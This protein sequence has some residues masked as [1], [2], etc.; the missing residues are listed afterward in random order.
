MKKKVSETSI[1]GDKITQEQDDMSK[2]EKVGSI[3]EGTKNLSVITAPPYK[4]K[5]EYK[6]GTNDKKRDFR[7]RESSVSRSNDDVL[8]RNLNAE[9]KKRI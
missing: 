4:Y 5:Q 6:C 3:I 7:T 9:N 2:E 8:A 1:T